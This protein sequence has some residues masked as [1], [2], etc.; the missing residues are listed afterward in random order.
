VWSRS[1]AAHVY[2]PEL[3]LPHNPVGRYNDRDRVTYLIS[4]TANGWIVWRNY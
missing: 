2:F 1:I 4:K 3:D